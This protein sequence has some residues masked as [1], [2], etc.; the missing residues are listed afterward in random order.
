M[1][2]LITFTMS[3]PVPKGNNL[4][5]LHQ[6]VGLLSWVSIFVNGQA[7]P[8]VRNKE[9][10]NAFYNTAFSNN[11]VYWAGVS[12]HLRSSLVATSRV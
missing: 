4:V 3:V 5:G 6:N 9:M 1:W 12:I 10:A 2:V 8:C 11:T 7:G